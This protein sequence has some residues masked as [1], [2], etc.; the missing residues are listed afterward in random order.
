MQ[1]TMGEPPR[2]FQTYVPPGK[3]SGETFEVPEGGRGT[4]LERR[5]RYF[6]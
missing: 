5:F 2:K 6:F 4:H 3:K 1:F